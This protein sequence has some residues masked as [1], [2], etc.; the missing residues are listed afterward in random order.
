VY[1]EIEHAV[2]VTGRSGGVN[3]DTTT[4]MDTFVQH[5]AMSHGMNFALVNA[6]VR[7]PLGDGGGTAL[8]RVAVIG[9]A[10]AGPMLPHAETNVGGRS[11]EQYQRAGVGFQLAGGV[12]VRLAGWLSAIADYKFGHAR[13]QIDIVDGTGQMSANVHQVAFGLALG[14]SR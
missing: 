2:H 3:V 4:R 7:M 8:S 14:L 10:G 1:A 11:R 12:D 9:R 13:P 5:Y 6:V